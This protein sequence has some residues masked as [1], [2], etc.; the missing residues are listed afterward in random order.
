MAT[1][2][3]RPLVSGPTPPRLIHFRATAVRAVGRTLWGRADY[4]TGNEIKGIDRLRGGNTPTGPYPGLQDRGSSTRRV[5]AGASRTATPLRSVNRK[6]QDSS[7]WS[8]APNLISKSAAA[9]S[10]RTMLTT[11]GLQLAVDD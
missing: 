6:V 1:D 4:A 10:G 3:A 8:R 11:T 9:P 5:W 2:R 7:P